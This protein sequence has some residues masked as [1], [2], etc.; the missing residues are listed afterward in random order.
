MFHVADFADFRPLDTGLLMVKVIKELH[1]GAFEWATY[2][3]HVNPTGQNHL[4]LLLGMA[5]AESVFDVPL[6]EFVAAARKLTD[7]GDWSNRMQ[8][9]LL[10]A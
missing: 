6:A 1:P 10:Y 9:F 7:P 8:P 2:P 3:T 5:G 4:D